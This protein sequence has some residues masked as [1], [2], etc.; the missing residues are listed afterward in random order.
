M[1]ILYSTHS[2]LHQTIKEMYSI[3][4]STLYLHCSYHIPALSL[5]SSN[6]NLLSVPRVCTTVA[7][8]GFSIAV[9][10]V[11][12]LLPSGI[13][14]YL[15]SHTH[16][17][18]L[19]TVSGLQFPLVVPQIRPL[20]A[21]VYYKSF[22]LFTYLLTYL[23]TISTKPNCMLMTRSLQ[24]CCPD[25]SELALTE[26]YRHHGGCLQL[27]LGQ[28]PCTLSVPYKMSI[29]RKNGHFPGKNPTQVTTM[30][31]TSCSKQLYSPSVDSRMITISTSLCF[32]SQPGRLV[33]WTTLAN[34]SNERLSLQ[35]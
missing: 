7:S 25:T 4:R 21:T 20:A 2:P 34:R 26:I 18:V 33:T 9:P 22:Y 23:L 17:V 15:S 11:W 13:C 16:S 3:V 27:I 12:N 32:V 1:E 6:T 5:Q 24:L 19:P 10:S 14:T 35:T 28:S 31:H 8:R 29:H 30:D